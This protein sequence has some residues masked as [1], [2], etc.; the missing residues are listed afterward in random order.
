M[1]QDRH[2]FGG[3]RRGPDEQGPAHA[4][5]ESGFQKARDGAVAWSFRNRGRGKRPDAIVTVRKLALVLAVGAVVLLWG[6]VAHWRS[7]TRRL[8]TREMPGGPDVTV[9]LGYKNRGGRANLINRYR[10]RAALRSQQG[11]QEARLVLSGGSVGGAVP[12]AELMACYVRNQQGYRGELVIEASSRST[13][14]N[15][16]NVLPCLE[17]AGRIRIVSNSLHAEKGRAYLWTLR[18]DL[19]ER[20]VKADEYRFGELI[21]LK[22]VMA[23]IGA[24][25]LRGL[26]RV[27]T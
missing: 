26:P 1:N 3:D 14:E 2:R 11:S 19:A 25:N 7:S 9:V 6:E 4:S 10:V 15:I 22:P 12:E 8:G 13:W 21:L 23:L 24:R 17:D 27:L 16:E 20:L 18:P 5:C